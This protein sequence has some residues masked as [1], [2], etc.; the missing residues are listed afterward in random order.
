MHVYVAECRSIYSAQRIVTYF[1]SHKFIIKMCDRDEAKAQ[2]LAKSQAVSLQYA[3]QCVVSHLSLTFVIIH[4][5]FISFTFM[6]VM[7]SKWKKRVK[8]F[9]F[10]YY[11]YLNA[12]NKHAVNNETKIK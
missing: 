9:D 11:Y 5:V 3:V 10:Y 8:H 12:S 7:C 1:I 6:I 4:F 2:M